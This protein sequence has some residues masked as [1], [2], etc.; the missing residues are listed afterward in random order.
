VDAIFNNPYRILGLYSNASQ[1]DFQRNRSQMAAFIAAGKPV[2]FN[3]DFPNLPPVKR[4]EIGMNSALAKIQLNQDKLLHSL[5]WFSNGSHVDEP[6]FAA[7]E[8]GNIVKALDIWTKVTTGHDSIRKYL[9]A[10]NNLGTLKLILATKGQ[11]IDQREL[12]EA[13]KLKREL[14]EH[15]S[16]NEYVSSITDNTYKP[17]SKKVLI[18]FADILL[19]YLS[20]CVMQGKL[21][22]PAAGRLF[23]TA[24]LELRNYAIEKLSKPLLTALTERISRNME[25]RKA[26][27]ARALDIGYSLYDGS[28]ADL[29]AYKELCGRDNMDY[30][31]MADR[32]AEEVLQ[33]GIDHFNHHK[34]SDEYRFHEKCKSLLTKARNIS[35]GSLVKQRIDENLSELTK[36]VAD[37]PERL[38]FKSINTE[39]MQIIASVDRAQK[40]DP[41]VKLAA[42]LVNTISPLLQQVRSKLGSYDETYVNLCSMV[43]NV[44][45]Q[46]IINV[47]NKY[48]DAL[49]SP[50]DYILKQMLAGGDTNFDKATIIAQ[51]KSSLQEAWDVFPII[52]ALEYNN[53]IRDR[54]N[55]N[56]QILKSIMIDLGINPDSISN[57]L[58]KLFFG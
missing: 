17:T 40:S 49:S 1:R 53:A 23:S 50:Y 4:D 32:L 35:E 10:F 22:L 46:I 16:F 12:G 47:N 26:F 29:S 36:W 27:P 19:E 33:C 18:Q 20:I 8:T 14:I 38:K 58:K 9:S 13:I 6:A 5:F 52:E 48:Q 28:V 39:F 42:N 7:L 24:P 3:T 25:D 34:E 55:Q 41:T 15:V 2:S 44:A 43:A 51:Y 57:K 45:L 37:T 11:S 30:Q 21:T 56:K 31:I 54:I